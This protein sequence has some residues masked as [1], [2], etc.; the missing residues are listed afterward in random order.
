MRVDKVIL[1]IGKTD[2]LRET[3]NIIIFCW[4]L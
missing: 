3:F 4:N 2:E 1:E